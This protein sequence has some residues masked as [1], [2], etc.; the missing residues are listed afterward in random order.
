MTHADLRRLG[1]VRQADGSYAKD[2]P[3]VARL[4]H[5]LAQQNP[6]PALVRDSQGKTK[7]TERITLRITRRSARLL[8]AD[9]FAGGCKPLID[10][11]RYAGL[12]P[13]D[14]PDKVE[15]TFIQEKVKKAEEETIVELI[16][17]V[18]DS[19]LD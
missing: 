15:I 6:R 14:S 1:F 4:S 18:L 7:S 9:N 2:Q 13:D 12:I 11:I 8:D 17:R 19:C 5:A 16:G 10:Q 3:K